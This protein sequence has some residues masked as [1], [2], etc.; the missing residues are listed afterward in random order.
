MAAPPSGTITVRP[1]RYTT[2]RDSTS[3]VLLCRSSGI[4]NQSPNG[5]SCSRFVARISSGPAWSLARAP[6]SPRRPQ[7][8]RSSSPPCIPGALDR[9]ESF[10]D[11]LR[12]SPSGVM[13]RNRSSPSLSSHR[14]SLWG[15]T[16]IRS[17]CLVPSRS[18]TTAVRA[19][20]LRTLL[21]SGILIRIVPR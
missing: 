12:F 5:G 8:C 21:F 10:P 16:Y 17:T 18:T 3:R 2:M 13:S 7:V 20:R 14:R 4:T 9:G 19:P 6:T 1:P 11:C 15:W